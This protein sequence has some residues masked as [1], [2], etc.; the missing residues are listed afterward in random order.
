MEVSALAAQQSTTSSSAFSSLTQNID[1]FLTL[2]TTQLRNQD[3]LNPLDTEKFT[4]Q[5]VQFASVEQSIQT[6]THLEALIA[7]QAS[8]ERSDAFALLGKT[9]RVESETAR[10]DD[11][12]A[13][14][15]IQ[16]PEGAAAISARILD[17]GGRVVATRAFQPTGETTEF[18]WNGLTDNRARA[19]DGL[20]TLVV[21]ARG[22][23]GASVPARIETA[24]EVSAVAFGDDGASLETSVGIV[25]LAAVRRVEV[26][27][28]GR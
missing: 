6:N 23:D 16:L 3:P 19:R 2:L 25:P 8:N 15:T 13:A 11:T 17:S 12:G 5:L 10:L 9:A 27:E 14:W 24:A 22:A 20:Y 18:L 1:T 26:Q 28:G 4:E 7:L 21:N